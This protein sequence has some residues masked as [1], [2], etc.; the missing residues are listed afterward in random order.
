MLY[1]KRSFSKKI[2]EKITKKM[3]NLWDTTI[4]VFEYPDN[5]RRIYEIFYVSQRKNFSNWIGKVSNNFSKDIDWWSASPSSRN[6]YISELF[7]N[8]CVLETLKYLKRKKKFPDIII[9]KSNELK[10]IINFNFGKSIIKVKKEKEFFDLL[11]KIYF[12]FWP[13][14][15]SF[16]IVSLSRVFRK[17]NFNLSENKNILIDIF[18]TSNNLT[19][20]RF[21]NNLEKKLKVKKNIYFVPTIVNV[22]IFKLPSL[23][24]KIRNNKNFI[25]KEDFI[26]F[27]DILFAFNYLFRKKKFYIN[28][29][30]YK[31]WNLDN[32]IKEEFSKYSNFQAIL[33][34]LQNYC[35]AKNLKKRNV[36]LKK[37]I[38]WFENTTVDKGWNF[39]FR[40]FF[41]ETLTVGYQSYTLYRQFMC[42][43]PS[44]SEYLHKVIPQ[45][46]VVIGKAYKKARKEF[47]KKIK[48][49]VGPALRFSHVFL[50]KFNYKR[51]YNILV[52]L[53][54]DLIESKKILSSVIDAK[55]VASGKKIFIKSHPLLSLSKI[56][57]KKN[58]PE[59][60]VE[61]EGDF[62]DIAKN[63]RIIISAGISSSIVESFAYGCAI[64]MPYMN[65]N[66]YYNFK[67]LKI[68]KSSYKICKDI[69]ELDREINHFLN[70]KAKDTRKR[71]KKSILLRPKLFQK[72]TNNNL[73]IFS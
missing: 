28:Y 10:N 65:K 54:L 29:E 48:I 5:F 45:K 24:T 16:T 2:K 73:K 15:F 19:T 34:S 42:K 13:L 67:Y 43:H 61:L 55:Y 8:I 27:T 35:F 66:D 56:I 12:I 38:D 59:N 4:P 31:G 53:N 46:I 68:P 22:N 63:S 17:N 58:I 44:N 18:V 36:K 32:L 33:I 51:K 62:Y 26:N 23:I 50:Q 49:D 64:V 6:T 37:V 1:G 72:T 3:N 71:I 25:L 47:C 40:K 20:N 69:Y 70:E 41:P 14:I 30:N 39:G 11:K 60:F 21:Y 57:D 52:S 7:H 9:V